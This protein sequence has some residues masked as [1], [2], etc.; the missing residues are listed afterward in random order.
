MKK[1]LIVSAIAVLL[2]MACSTI[3][4]DYR[5]PEYRKIAVFGTLSAPVDYDIDS[6]G[7][8]VESLVE[9]LVEGIVDAISENYPEWRTTGELARICTRCGYDVYLVAPEDYFEQRKNKV[10]VAHQKRYEDWVD[11]EPY[12]YR[13]QMKSLIG[14]HMEPEAYIMCRQLD[15]DDDEESFTVEMRRWRND[16][17]IFSMSYGYFL[18]HYNEFF[19]GADIED[20]QPEEAKE[21]EEDE[22]DTG[23]EPGKGDRIK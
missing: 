5:P 20:P 13:S 4:K 19:C 14:E 15:P 18:K 7:D 10:D 16:K 17:M 23:I 12:R 22:E 3:P 21:I 11:S 8:L 1:I 6:K 9:G 2:S